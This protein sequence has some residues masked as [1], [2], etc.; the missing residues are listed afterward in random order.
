MSLAQYHLVQLLQQQSQQR[1]DSIALEGFEL[2][3]PWDRVSWKAFDSI[4]H[5]VAKAMIKFGLQAQDTAVILSQN[6]PQWTCAD[7]GLLKARAIVVPVY[8]SST[9]EQASFIINDAGAKVLFVDD[10]E[11][12]HMACKLQAV[13]PSVEYLVVFD[14]NVPLLDTP[15]H[16]HFDSLITE[17]LSAQDRALTE[18]LQAANLDDLL[19]LIYTS[20]TT[21]DPKG[22]ML[23]YRNMASTIRQHDTCLNF[24][25]GDTSLAFLP[26]SHVFERSWSFF[27]LCRGGR[28]VY[29]KDTMK[30]KEAIV[31]VRPHTLCVVPRF[32]EKVY[33]AV[34]DKVSKAPKSRQRL[35]HWAMAAG[36]RQFEVNQGRAKTS[37]ILS[38]QWVVANKLVFSKLQAVLGGRLKFMPCGGAALDMTVGNFFHGINLPVLCGYGMTETNAT[39]TMNTLNNRVPGS[40]GKPLPETEVKLGAFDEI[41]VRGDAVMRGYYKRPDD[42]AATFEDGW[43]KT[44][45]AGRFDEQGNLF[46]TDRIKELMKTSNGKY[47]APQRVEGKVGSCPFIEQVAIIADG[48]NF[49]SALI[50][51]SFEALEYWAKEQGLVFDSLASLLERAEVLA[52]FEQR[53]I[54]L[55]H[56]LAAF[57]QIKK[58]S[59]LPEA[60]TIE[61]GLITPTLKLRR[62]AI[63]QRYAPEIT[64]MYAG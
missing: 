31:A 10:A 26:L 55:Q 62:K 40:N 12:Y 7:I 4:S 9:Q 30:I 38:L 29:L 44:G 5:Q 37:A 35:F 48:R 3:A 2:A 39:V 32:L 20:G 47:I 24:N 8:P 36:Q 60:F 11:Q 1:A 15:N 27:A 34:Q 43:L 17:D 13:C 57:E 45:D 64:A 41:M 50:V 22:V 61:A 46:I 28:N 51:P 54:H 19:T 52:H 33:S 63:Y 14:A 58:F 56:D 49:V 53:L 42:T 16:L 25:P 6:C 23:D 59:L 18:R 21:G